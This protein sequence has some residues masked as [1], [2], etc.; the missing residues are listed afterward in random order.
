MEAVKSTRV[1]SSKAQALILITLAGGDFYISKGDYY[2][3]NFLIYS[4]REHY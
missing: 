1:A 2:R 4:L 3:L